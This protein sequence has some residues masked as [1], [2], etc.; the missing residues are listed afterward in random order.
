MISAT[1]FR[2]SKVNA[3][4]APGGSLFAQSTFRAVVFAL[5]ETAAEKSERADGVLYARRRGLASEDSSDTELHR[6]ISANL[7][8]CLQRL[9]GLAPG[10]LIAPLVK[11][12]GIRGYSNLEFDLFSMLTYHPGITV[13]DAL[14]LLDFLARVSGT[15]RLRLVDFRLFG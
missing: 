7:S 13:Q 6:F 10:V 1:I 15:F 11:L 4:V 14:P 5:I 12:V 8:E 9:P 2:T 3:S